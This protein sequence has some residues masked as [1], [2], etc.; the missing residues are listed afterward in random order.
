MKIAFLSPFYPYR[1]GIAQFSDSLYLSLSK[2]A[3]VKAFS[4]SRQ[5]P[6]MLFPG[7]S[8]LTVESDKKQDFPV[9]RIL[10]SINP[11]TYVKTAKEIIKYK[12]DLLIMPYWMPFF[13]PSMGWAAKKA[14]KAGIKV[15][16]ILHNVVPHEPRFGD[17]AL[18]NFYL[19]NSDAY[20]LLSES[21]K[22]ELEELRPGAKFIIHSLPFHDHYTPRIP[23]KEARKK[24]NL[25]QDK[26]IL[27]YFGFIR[28]YK[29]LDLLIEAMKYLDDSYL[30]LIV[31]EVYGEFTKYQEIIDKN[32]LGSKIVKYI[33]YIPD[34]EI[35]V[36]F[37]AA[38]VCVLTYKNATQS[39]I[40]GISYQFDV[41]VIVTDVGGF[42]ELV[43]EN[44]TALIV[45][46]PDP[47]EISDAIKKYFAE[48]LK[49]KFIP[50]IAAVREKHS[51]S[52]L[53]KD[54]IELYRTIV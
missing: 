16:S 48:G 4:F 28:D 44:K 33:N 53:A 39:G 26:K 31:G 6:K 2:L 3:E 8:Q 5:Y 54:V 18:T 21:N 40:V 50:N 20:I 23:E 47:V 46:N 12:P 35:P 51:W 49:E 11:L 41:P 42:R 38:D 10:D 32:N 7:T 36:Y 34:S 30:L 37:S 19:R 1:G 25:P 17:M 52:G 43:E 24:L 14:K 13:A 22:K 9:E 45:K 15:I 27:I 29:G